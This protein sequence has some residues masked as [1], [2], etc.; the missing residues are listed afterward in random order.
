MAKTDRISL[1]AAVLDHDSRIEAIE[2]A[3]GLG[4]PVAPPL[5]LLELYDDALRPVQWDADHARAWAR[6]VLLLS[7]VSI[8]VLV[9]YTGD[10]FPWQGA[11]VRLDEFH[12]RGFSVMDAIAHVEA[13]AT[14]ALAAQGLGLIRPRDVMG[15]PPLRRR[16]LAALNDQ[17]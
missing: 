3:L 2:S 9:R 6:Q 14:S 10:P 7:P 15:Y 4:R 17:E 8:V 12:R 16:A 11:L 1:R 13:V 5:R